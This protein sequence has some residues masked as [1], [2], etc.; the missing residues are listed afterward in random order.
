M[1][2]VGVTT[3]ARIL[4]KVGEANG[5]PTA[6]HLAAYKGFAPA[7]RSSGSSVARQTALPKASLPPPG[8]WDA[9]ASPRPAD[10]AEE[11]HG[12]NDGAAVTS[13]QGRVITP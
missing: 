11:G 7:A 4:L 13:S 6:G 12:F 8:S 3:G 9:V 2:G 1:P 5:F 10:L